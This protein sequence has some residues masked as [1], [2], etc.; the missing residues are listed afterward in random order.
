ML[1]FLHHFRRKNMRPFKWLQTENLERA[2]GPLRCEVLI[3]DQFNRLRVIRMLDKNGTCR[4]LA[5]TRLNTPAWTEEIFQIDDKIREGAFI[6]KAFDGA[7]MNPRRLLLAALTWKIPGN[8]K[9]LLGIEN[10]RVHVWLVRLLVRGRNRKDIAYGDIFE[11]YPPE[12]MSWGPAWISKRLKTELDGNAPQR[13]A[14]VLAS[15]WS[16]TGFNPAA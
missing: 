1:A 16:E 12:V 3:H 9:R 2:Y 14:N 4:L 8:V 6:G 11:I 5:I 10:Q 15:L 13:L 7:G